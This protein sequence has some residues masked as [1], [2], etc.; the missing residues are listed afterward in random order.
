[1]NAT[2]FSAAGHGKPYTVKT[3]LRPINW[4]PW[5]TTTGGSNFSIPWCCDPRVSLY[6]TEFEEYP[7]DFT[8]R[9]NTKK[10]FVQ[11]LKK[12]LK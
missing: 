3:F 11:G 4:K 6:R 2:A 12:H 9:R 1:L 5:T 10:V 8:E 7:T